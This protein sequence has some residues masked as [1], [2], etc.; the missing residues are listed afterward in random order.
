MLGRNWIKAGDMN[1]PQQSSR[2]FFSLLNSKHHAQVHLSSRSLPTVTNAFTHFTDN[3]SKAQSHKWF[4]RAQRQSVVNSW[5]YPKPSSSQLWASLLGRA[6]LERPARRGSCRDSK[7]CWPRTVKD[8]GSPR[9]LLDVVDKD[10]AWGLRTDFWFLNSSMPHCP[11]TA[12]KSQ[13]ISL[14]MTQGKYLLPLGNRILKAV[15]AC[16]M[17]CWHRG[18]MCDDKCVPP[19][20]LKWGP[21][22]AETETFQWLLCPRSEW[23]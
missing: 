11:F 8:V 12:H 2:Q 1:V 23:L 6:I 22:V 7:G 3:K 21:K 13:E 9:E 5:F 15:P 10:W 20:S 14:L 18:R 4:P 16:P 17:L 19:W